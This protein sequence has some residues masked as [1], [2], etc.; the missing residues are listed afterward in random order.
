VPTRAVDQFFEIGHPLPIRNDLNYVIGEQRAIRPG[1]S[2]IEGRFEGENVDAESSKGRMPGDE[3]HPPMTQLP[4]EAA[5][6]G[7]QGG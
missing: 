6:D 3:P 2:A 7:S 1:I 4:F 5:E